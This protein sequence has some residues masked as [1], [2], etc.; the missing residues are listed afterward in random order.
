MWTDGGDE[1][2]KGDVLV[3][4]DTGGLKC[5]GGELLVFVGDHVDAERKFIDV[6][7]L[8]AEV[9]NADFGVGNAAVETG[10]RVGLLRNS[11]QC[12]SRLLEAE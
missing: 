7:A 6:G 5:F 12:V 1:G 8:A 4:T 9:E 3:G 10:F 11:D 2:K